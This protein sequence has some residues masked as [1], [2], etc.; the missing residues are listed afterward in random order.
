MTQAREAQAWVV[1]GLGPPRLRRP[2]CASLRPRS[3]MA[4]GNQACEPQAAATQAREP[5]AWVAHSGLKPPTPISDL[6]LLSLS[7]SGFFFFLCSSLMFWWF[8]SDLLLFISDI[9]R[10][11][12][13]RFPCNHHVE[14]YATSDV[15]R[16]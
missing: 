4:W 9:N 8:L 11:L 7:V 13:T 14:K 16:T 5:Q 12:E 10:V 2:R 6:D 15:I 3:H 1:R